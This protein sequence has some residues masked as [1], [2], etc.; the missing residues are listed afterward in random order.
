MSRASRAR[1]AQHDLAFTAD[2]Y[3]ALYPE[4]IRTVR[5]ARLV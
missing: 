4:L 2:A 5:P 1:A 3:R